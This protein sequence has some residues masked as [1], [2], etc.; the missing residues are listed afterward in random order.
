ML[1]EAVRRIPPPAMVGVAQLVRAPGCGPGCRGFES[2]RSP[3]VKA[4]V[5]SLGRHPRL[6]SPVCRCPILGVIWEPNVLI[7]PPS[8]SARRRHGAHHRLLACLPESEGAR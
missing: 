5:R 8:E 2:H 7:G 3:H 4:L 1:W 6:G